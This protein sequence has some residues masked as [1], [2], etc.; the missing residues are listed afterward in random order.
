[1]SFLRF[2]LP[3]GFR[4]NLPVT[5][6]HLHRLR[7]EILAELGLWGYRRV[8]TPAIEFSEVIQQASGN[9]RQLFQLV[10]PQTGEVLALRPDITPQIARVAATRLQAGDE[11]LRLAYYG[12]VYRLDDHSPYPRRE[13]PQIGAEL[14]GADSI[15]ADV[16]VLA[17]GVTSLRRSGLKTLKID[18]GDV[19]IGRHYLDQLTLSEEDQQ[20]VSQLFARKNH[21]DLERLLAERNQS[22]KLI[23]VLLELLD[24]YGDQTVLARARR[25]L[26]APETLRRI[27]EME[28]VLVALEDHGISSEVLLDFGEARQWDYYTGRLFHVLVPGMGI[29]VLA[30]GRYNNL[31][32]QYGA[33]RAATGFAID[34]DRLADAV[35]HAAETSPHIAL[36]DAGAG[37]QAV[38]AAA[39]RLREAGVAVLGPFGHGSPP[40]TV[41]VHVTGEDALDVPSADRANDV[42]MSVDDLVHWIRSRE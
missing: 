11:V 1:M 26:H 7:G 40:I 30:G 19:A 28:Q 9:Q 12:H 34:L 37:S 41:D 8:I 35:P 3:K 16:E 38:W 10:D 17:L 42:T 25:I 14:I 24:L 39:R 33:E 23:G 32:G 13:I 20:R 29:P 22:A 4:D 15:Y 2:T 36:H 6:E 27:D 31:I 5:A 21:S 18:L